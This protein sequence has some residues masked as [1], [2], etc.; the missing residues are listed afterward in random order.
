MTRM[1]ALRETLAAKT[2]HRADID[3]VAGD[4]S[5]SPG[6]IAELWSLLD[7]SQTAVAWHAAWALEKIASRNPELLARHRAGIEAR[8]MTESRPGIQR[9]LLSIVHSMPDSRR[10]NVDLLDFCLEEMFRP[11][12]STA[13]RALCG[14]IACS[15][16]LRRAELRNELRACMESADEQCLPAAV[17]S[18]R[19]GIL[20]QLNKKVK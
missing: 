4:A 5:A 2:M 16:C 1:T 12:I 3:R 6:M 11:R 17:A 15:L 20:K 9:L 7:D 19:R 8:A 18:V 14:K 10:I 13:S